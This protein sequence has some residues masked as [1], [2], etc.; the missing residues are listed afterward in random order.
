MN[1]LNQKI[2]FA[3][4]AYNVKF[5][6]EKFENEEDNKLRKDKL[7]KLLE[8]TDVTK[9]NAIRKPKNER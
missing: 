1:E 7:N 8:F 6:N 3:R 9:Q 5:L 2:E 4:E